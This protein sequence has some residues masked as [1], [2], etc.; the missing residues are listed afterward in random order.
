M[1]DFSDVTN[2]ISIKDSEI[3]AA[4]EAGLMLHHELE[5]Q[6]YGFA[7]DEDG[8]YDWQEIV[9]R[10]EW[11]AAHPDWVADYHRNGGIWAYAD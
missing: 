3:D 5:T 2:Y 1:T 6:E 8:V 7:T 10:D 4:R 11:F 9:V